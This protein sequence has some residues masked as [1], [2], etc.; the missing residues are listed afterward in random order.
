ML[1]VKGKY[2]VSWWVSGLGA[3]V[4]VNTNIKQY[5]YRKICIARHEKQ[6]VGGFDPGHESSAAQ[7]LGEQ[8]RQWSAAEAL[9]WPLGQGNYSS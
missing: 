9:D 4:V 2:G 3:E 1:V 8:V 5:E 7:Y 6:L